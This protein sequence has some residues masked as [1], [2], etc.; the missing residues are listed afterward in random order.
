MI[1]FHSF[2]RNSWVDFSGCIWHHIA[3]VTNNLLDKPV[4]SL[5]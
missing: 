1:V 4:A 5:V 3:V 2:D